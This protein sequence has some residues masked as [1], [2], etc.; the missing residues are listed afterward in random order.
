LIPLLIPAVNEELSDSRFFMLAR[1]SLRFDGK[2]MLDGMAES[3]D[4][5]GSLGAPING[6]ESVGGGVNDRDGL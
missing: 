4:V 3:T 5:V 6:I 1:I 2:D